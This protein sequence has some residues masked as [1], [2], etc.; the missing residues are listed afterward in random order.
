MSRFLYAWL[1]C[2][3]IGRTWSFA[4]FSKKLHRTTQSRLMMN[5]GNHG[6]GS[7]FLPLSQIEGDEPA[8]RIV[9]VAGLYPGVT[10]EEVMAPKSYPA[11]PMGMW[12]FDFSD[13][14][15]PQMGTVAL[16]PSENVQM[17]EDPVVLVGPS[18]ALGL[19]LRNNIE[20]EVLILIDR[21]DCHFVD[22]RFFLF[23]RQDGSTVIQWSDSLEPGEVVLGRVILVTVP[24]VEGMERQNS[25][26]MEESD[27]Y[28]V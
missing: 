18:S 21:A 12:Q 2:T 14:D 3:Y 1:A 17:A 15:G 28:S 25:G 19:S 9:Q 8:P 11:A 6:E 27:D 16:Q 23:A 4:G 22:N 24:H 7:R 26:F 10:R 20:T 5:S 13:P